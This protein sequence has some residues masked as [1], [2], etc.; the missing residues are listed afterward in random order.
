[1]IVLIAAMGTNRVIGIEG[2]LPWHIPQDL[3]RFKK[4]TMGCPLIMGRATFDSIGRP[5]PGRPNIV[6]STNPSFRFSGVEVARS[7]A[8]ALALAR[9]HAPDGSEIFVIGGGQIYRHFLAEARRIELTV[10]D[11][12]PPGDTT[13]PEISDSDWEMVASVEVT[14]P[15]RLEYQTFVRRQG[16]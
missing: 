2:E 11:G 10:V 4:L 1:M 6:L 8:E 14:G 9:R 3:A 7:P 12:A 16:R 13:F 15:P 5:L